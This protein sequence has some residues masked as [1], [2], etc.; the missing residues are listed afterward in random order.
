MTT[1]LGLGQREVA[2]VAADDDIA[3]QRRL[4]SAAVGDP[5]HRSDD[6]LDAVAVGH[7][8]GRKPP[9]RAVKRAA[10]PY[11][12]AIEKYHLLLEHAKGA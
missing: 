8:P 11:K 9:K 2:V 1:N 3:G 10:R 4:E 12:N 5:V 7:C 6:R